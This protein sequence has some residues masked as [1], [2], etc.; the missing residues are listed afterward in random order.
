MAKYGVIFDLDGVIAKTDGL[1]KLAWFKFATKY[2]TNISEEFLQQRV[3][4]QTNDVAL[5]ALSGH[6][7]A[8]QKKT[9][10]IEKEEIFRQILSEQGAQP[11]EGL[12]QLLHQ[13]E[14]EDIPKAIATT[15]IL[16]N[17]EAVLSAVSLEKYFKTIIYG[18]IDKSDPERYK[19]AADTLGF[20]DNYGRC[21]VFEDSPKGSRI[22]KED[23]M[24]VVAITKQPDLF[25]HADSKAEDFTEINIA[26]LDSLFD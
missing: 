17:V 20:K 19:R 12:T 11:V 4:G 15:A 21:I 5:R 24:K 22:A 7:T 13:L 10:A 1:H 6:L 26:K 16:E 8:E 2:N 14:K 9:Y 3:Y 23:G 18:K 25:P